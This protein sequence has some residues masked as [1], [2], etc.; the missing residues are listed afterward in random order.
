MID[1]LWVFCII[2]ALLQVIA[3]VLLIKG[4]GERLLVVEE[5]RHLYHLDRVRILTIILS[6]SAIVFCI[7]FPLMMTIDNRNGVI[8]A[9]GAILAVVVIVVILI[10]TWAKK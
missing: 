3:V 6:I 5:K 10:N 1:T 4:R 2:F 7:V 9:A 8:L